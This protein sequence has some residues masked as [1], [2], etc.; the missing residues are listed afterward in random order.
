M[1]PDLGDLATKIKVLENARNVALSLSGSEIQSLFE[2][3]PCGVKTCWK[4]IKEP[5]QP[6]SS[7]FDLECDLVNCQTLRAIYRFVII[8]DLL[9][10]F[11]DNLY[12]CCFLC[13]L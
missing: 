7:E 2:K 13:Y 1:S 5:N 3:I 9:S 4:A 8:S 6:I 11:V 12:K 10:V